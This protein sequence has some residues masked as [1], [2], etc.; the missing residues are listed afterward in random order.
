MVRCPDITLATTALGWQPAI[1]WREGLS[2][3]WPGSRRRARAV[4]LADA[5]RCGPDAGTRHQRDLPRPGGRAGRGRPDRRRGRRGTV[6]PPQARQA[7]G[8]VLGL[9]AAGEVGGLVPGDRG[10]AARGPGRRGLL[11]RSGRLPAGRR[12]RPRRPL[13]LP[14]DQV[15]R[16]GAAVP[17][18]GAA[19]AGPGRRPLRPAPRG[20]RRL[21][22]P[23]RPVRRH[24]R[25]G[26]PTGAAKPPPTW[27]G[28]TPAASS[29][30]WP[31]RRCRTRW[32]CSTS[33][34]PRTWASC[35][36]ATSTR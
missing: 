8:P 35:T 11:L 24:Q 21:G 14:A 5:G 10:A 26:R 3:P 31:A 7:P 4:R 27:P 16:A 18:R 20:A 2:R 6:Q 29:R 28:S 13:G 30:C 15:R 36:P 1:A 12:A 25:A 9:G 17:G 34:P 32:G 22:R 33:R 23:G 19:R